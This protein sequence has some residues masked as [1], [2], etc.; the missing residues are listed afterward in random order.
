[1]QAIWTALSDFITGL[2][3][4]IGGVVTGITGQPVILAFV[5]LLPLTSIALGYLFKFLGKKR[6]GKKG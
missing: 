1:M 5:I 3:T 2:F 4:A 6:K